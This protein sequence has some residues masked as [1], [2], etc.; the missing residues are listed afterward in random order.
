MTNDGISLNN[1]RIYNSGISKKGDVTVSVGTT[2]GQGIEMLL[3]EVHALREL[4]A[5]HQTEVAEPQEAQR[6]L[7]QLDQTIRS[8]DPGKDQV[9]AVLT[10]L[11]GRV[12]AVSVLGTA[13][14]KLLNQVQQILH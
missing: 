13:V 9:V 2:A 12:A 6:D 11:G 14:F 8:G 4:L 5:V 3:H 1:S 10:R 7:K